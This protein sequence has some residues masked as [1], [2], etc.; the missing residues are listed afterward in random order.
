M[1]K[2]Y[3]LILIA[4]TSLVGCVASEGTEEIEHAQVEAAVHG[5]G[6]GHDQLPEPPLG[7]PPGWLDKIEV[8]TPAGGQYWLDSDGV[9]PA[10]PGCHT[11]YALATCESQVDGTFGEWCEDE[12]TLVETNP[13]ANACHAHTDGI[14]HPDRFSCEAYCR[15]LPRPP[16]HHKFHH[17]R[18]VTDGDFCGAGL[19]SAHC[20]CW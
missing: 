18:C 1:S 13:G 16:R 6:H 19:D 12:D 3:T 2:L 15:G 4:I 9:D 5:H 7:Y 10:T 11:A 20:A 14:G 8:E 17:G